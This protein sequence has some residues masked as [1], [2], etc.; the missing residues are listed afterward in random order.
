MSQWGCCSRCCRLGTRRTWRLQCLLRVMISYMISTDGWSWYHILHAERGQ[1][2]GA[3]VGLP[4]IYPVFIHLPHG[5][6]PCL[7]SIV[8]CTWTHPSAL[9]HHTVASYC[10]M[11]IMKSYTK[12]Y[13]AG[14]FW[15]W[16]LYYDIIA[17]RDYVISSDMI[18]CMVTVLS[19]LIIWYWTAYDIIVWTSLYLI[20]WK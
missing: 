4:G 6:M 19:L 5:P 15:S 2:A 10:M 7:D 1:C 11:L 14:H 9:F 3:Q 16:F 18:S 17:N 13:N 12:S 20:T 8:C